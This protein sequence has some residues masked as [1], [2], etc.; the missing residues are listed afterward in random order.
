MSI[1]SRLPIFISSHSDPLLLS[2]PKTLHLPIP[3]LMLISSVYSICSLYNTV[4]ICFLTPCSFKSS[5]KSKW[6]NLLFP[7]T[8][9]YHWCILCNTSFKCRRDTKNSNG[10][11]ESPWKIPRF[12]FIVSRSVLLQIKFVFQFFIISFWIFF[13]YQGFLSQTLTSQRTAGEGRGSFFIPLYH[14]HPLTNIQI[15]MCNFAREM[16]IT[17]F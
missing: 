8:E 11:N 2:I 16:T 3:N 13:F 17:Y 14:F 6:F 4:N 5:I 10:D 7:L 1:T 12:K 15:F 9:L